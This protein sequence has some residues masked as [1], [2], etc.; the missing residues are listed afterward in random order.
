MA[1]LAR[2]LIPPEACSA[3]AASDISVAFDEGDIAILTSALVAC[4]SDTG[5]TDYK[6]PRCRQWGVK[7]IRPRTEGKDD[8]PRGGLFLRAGC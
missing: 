5:K 6:F 1:T 2:M 4:E 7:G 3:Q 8:A